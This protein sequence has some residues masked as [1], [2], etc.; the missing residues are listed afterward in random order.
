MKN[1][2]AFG[3]L[4]QDPF[5]VD[6]LF[7]DIFNG[8]AGVYVRLYFKETQR[9]DDKDEEKQAG[10]LKRFKELDILKRSYGLKDWDKKRIAIDE[11]APELRKMI[12]LELSI[13]IH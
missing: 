5:V 12:E 7:E 1:N 3:T 9:G 6:E 2:K 10:Y 13:Y 8:L 11:H 4:E